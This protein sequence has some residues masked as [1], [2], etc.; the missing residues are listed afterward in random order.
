VNA[1]IT[2]GGRRFLVCNLPDLG[3]VPEGA[4][5]GSAALLSQLTQSHNAE[6]LVAM[7]AMEAS[8]IG[9]EIDLLDVYGV[10]DDVLNNPSDFGFSNTTTPC[11]SG[12][13]PCPEPD[14]SVFWDRIHP[15]AAAHAI[16]G[17]MAADEVIGTFDHSAIIIR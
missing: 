12:V 10:F 5:S 17:R 9:V 1:L 8:A 3:R 16:L 11:L 6:L 15:T 2:A 14:R 13:T 4:A 7:T